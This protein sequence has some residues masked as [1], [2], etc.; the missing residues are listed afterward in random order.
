M[1]A[2][3]IHVIPIHDGW[4]EDETLRWLDQGLLLPD[5]EP[6]RWTV[7]ECYDD[8]F[9]EPDDTPR[10]TYPDSDYADVLILGPESK[11]EEFFA[12]AIAWIE[13]E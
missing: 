11:P 12:A 13:A 3:H 8:C 4:D 1:S 10:V 6:L 2:L 5:V 9:Y 7:V